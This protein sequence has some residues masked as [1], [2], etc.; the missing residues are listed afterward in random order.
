ME[1]FAH[2]GS[3]GT[4]PE[5]TIAA[6]LEAAR[7]PIQGVEFDVHLTKDR[8]LVVIHDEKINRTSNGKGFVKDLTLAQLRTFDFGSWFSDDFKGETIPTLRDVLEVFADTPHHLHIELKSDKFPYPGMVEKTIS[9]IEEMHLDIRV[10]LSSF[11]H[12]A[13][14]TVNQLAPHL[15]TAALFMEVLVDPLDYMQNIPADALHLFFPTAFRPSIQDVLKTGV[16]VRTF[17]VNKEKDAKALKDIGVSGIFTNFPEKM[18]PY[19]TIKS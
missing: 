13:I 17:T 6:F 16:T 3:S 9:L 1:I 14:R 2:R 11:D 8:E 7:L 4:H 18:L 19:T 5:N 12:G 15:E 10:T